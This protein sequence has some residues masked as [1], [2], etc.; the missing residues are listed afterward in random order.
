MR[1]SRLASKRFASTA[2]RPPPPPPFDPAKGNNNLLRGAFFA[3]GLSVV[4]LVVFDKEE[5]TWEWL[6]GEKKQKTPLQE[7]K[8]SVSALEKIT[9]ELL[10]SIEHS[11]PRLVPLASSP[12]VPNP[13]PK[14][15]KAVTEDKSPINWDLVRKQIVE[16]LD[17]DKWD[18]GSWGPVFVRLGKLFFFNLHFFVI[19]N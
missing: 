4:A 1:L 12:I 19:K 11:L 3:A 8:M 14:I 17:D 9:L 13:G 10:D 16:M 6:T 7:K 5:K 15:E 2:P 18:D